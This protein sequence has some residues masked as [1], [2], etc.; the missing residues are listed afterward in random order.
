MANGKKRKEKGT[1]LK[2]GHYENRKLRSVRG[3]ERK[4]KGTG[5]KTDHNEIRKLRSV[6]G[7]K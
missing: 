5:L 7:L 4:E 3:E 1:G 2:T 6:S